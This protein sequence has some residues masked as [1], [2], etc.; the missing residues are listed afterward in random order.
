VVGADEVGEATD[1]RERAIDLLPSQRRPRPRFGGEGLLPHR[2]AV[3]EAQQ[4]GSVRGRAPGHL[5]VEP[6]AC[7]L[8]DQPRRELL[9]SQAPLQRRVDRDVHDPHRERDRVRRR[10]PQR[11]LAVPAVGQVRQA[12]GD[13]S[14]GAGLLGEHPG[15]LTV[16]CDRGPERPDH[17]GQAQRDLYR[18]GRP[19]SARVRKSPDQ[20]GHHLTAGPVHQRVEVFGQGTTEHLGGQ[21]RVRRAARVR[22][23]APVIRL[24]RGLAVD[25]EPICQPHRDHG[26]VQAVL[27]RE[28]MPRSVARHKVPITSAVRSCSA[29]D[30][31][32]CG[33]TLRRLPRIQR[34]RRHGTA[35]AAL[36]RRAP[37][38]QRA[39]RVHPRQTLLR[40]VGPARHAPRRPRRRP[41][42]SAARAPA[43]RP[44]HS[45]YGCSTRPP[46][47]PQC[48]H[49]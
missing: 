26:R 4:L 20:A 27:E 11:A 37:R 30:P 9:A 44:Q 42:P 47:S 23:E 10:P 14:R 49:P 41:W 21:V 24:H 33:P 25:T 34:A 18:A 29:A 40:D 1:R 28:P 35:P 31:A 3:R 6:P 45:C 43:R 2:R 13:C 7:V 19:R 17:P 48:S 12:R 8:A 46:C 16:G 5:G 36:A 32:P 38:T 15:H 22:Q 39:V